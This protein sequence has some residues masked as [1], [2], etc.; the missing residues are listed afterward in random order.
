MHSQTTKVF[1]WLPVELQTGNVYLNCSLEANLQQ[2]SN[3]GLS[4]A[5]LCSGKVSGSLTVHGGESSMCLCM[6]GTVPLPSAGRLRDNVT[7]PV[8]GEQ[9]LPA[10]LP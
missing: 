6:A 10:L 9:I 4:N 3:P 2:N 1:F 5:N 7:Y 8:L